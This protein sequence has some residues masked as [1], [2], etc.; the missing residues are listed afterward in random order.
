MWGWRR[1]FVATFLPLRQLYFSSVFLNC[2]TCWS[3]WEWYWCVWWELSPFQ[4]LFRDL[5]GTLGGNV[6]GWVLPTSGIVPP[7]HCTQLHSLSLGFNG[8]SCTNDIYFVRLSW[9]SAEPKVRQSSVAKLHVDCVLFACQLCTIMAVF[10]Y[11]NGCT[12]DILSSNMW[13]VL[14]YLKRCDKLHFGSRIQ[15]SMWHL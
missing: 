10:F 13:V 4:V 1:P 12:L 9:N 5:D 14:T 6:G 7:N 3:C 15:E 8:T 11:K 2:G